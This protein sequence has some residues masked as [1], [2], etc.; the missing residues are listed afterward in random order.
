MAFV[1]VTRAAQLLG[2]PDRTLRH[3]CKEGHV[4]GAWQPSFAGSWLIP[5]GWI[6]ER[7]EAA[8]V[9]DV[10]D[11]APGRQLPIASEHDYKP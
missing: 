5:L 2:V 3:W 8:G 6:L 10:A 11:R 1:G 7:L 9:A 4:P